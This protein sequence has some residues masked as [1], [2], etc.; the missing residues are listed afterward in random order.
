[1]VLSLIHHIA[2]VPSTG[3]PDNLT[4]LW[5]QECLPSMESHFVV[6]ADCAL[7]TGAQ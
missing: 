4:F 3:I 2:R 6:M 7:A 5:L 1:M